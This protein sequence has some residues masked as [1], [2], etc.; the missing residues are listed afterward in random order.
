MKTGYEETATIKDEMLFSKEIT[1]YVRWGDLIGR[2]ALFTGIL[3]LLNTF[4]KAIIRKKN[5]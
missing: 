5:S 1:F 4:S 3:L 2:L